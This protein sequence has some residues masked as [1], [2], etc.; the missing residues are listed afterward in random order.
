MTVR[1]QVILA[2]DER[3]TLRRQAESEGMSLSAWLRKTALQAVAGKDRRRISGLED[4]RS[5]FAECD[6]REHG[7]EPDWEEH[8]A[9]IRRSRLPGADA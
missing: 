9:V 4:L 8:L 6:A 3:E 7:R 5:F 2:E 1:I